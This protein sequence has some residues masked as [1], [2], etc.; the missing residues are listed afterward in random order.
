MSQNNPAQHLRTWRRK[1]SLPGW[2]APLVLL[3]CC[4]LTYGILIP[5]LGVY[6]DDWIFLS[7]Y[8]KMGSAG[9]VRYFATNRPFWGLFYQV[10]LPLLGKTPWHWHLFGLFWHW[11]ASVALW[12]LVRLVW[13]R[14]AK[15]ALWAGL[16]FTV[17]P[18]FI[19]QPIAL[20]V[21]HMFLVYTSFILSICFFV[22]AQLQRRLH[23]S[24][25]RFWFW[26]VLA[27][28]TSLVNLLSM[29]YFLLL[30]LVQPIFL[31]FALSG[32][33]LSLH[34][35]FKHILQAWLPY[36]AMLVGVLLWRIFFFPYQTHN[37]QY[38]LLDRLR[39]SPI[40]G[41]IDLA[42][43]ML[44]DG[45]ETLAGTWVSAL[46]LPLSLP[47]ERLDYA[48]LVLVIA[49]MAVLFIALSQF[50]WSESQA[51]IPPQHGDAA[52]R[53]SAD[54]RQMMFAGGISMLIAGAP[55]WL[56]GITV[57]L[58]GFNSRFTLPFVFGASLLTSGFLLWLPFPQR[59]RLSRDKVQVLVL[60][61]ILGMGIGY[62]FQAQNLFR[63]EWLLQK[64]LY[65]QLAWRIPGL[66]PGT[67]VF[68]S[69]LPLYYNASDYTQ[70]AMFDWNWQPAP[71]ESNLPS[72]M[73]YALYYPNER[74]LFSSLSA[75]EADQPVYVDHLG[76]EFSGNT[77]QSVV[78][79]VNDPAAMTV[80]CLHVMLPE[81]DANNPYFPRLERDVIAFSN[82][83]LILAQDVRQTKQLI[84][85]IF[86]GEPAP[87]HCYYFQKIDLAFQL[88]QWRKAIRLY[89]EA[90]AAGYDSWIDT[91]LVPVIGSFA[92]A[93]DWD[94]AVQLTNQMSKKAFYPLDSFICNLWSVIE[95]DTPTSPAK[96]DAKLRINEKY[97]CSQ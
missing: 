4:A 50:R 73:N 30:H 15:A 49:S 58:D 13:P 97:G 72:R 63:R 18:G 3:A 28:I 55:F 47:W 85:E 54:G 31:W 75:L 84:P 20:T 83:A 81:I 48:Y 96:S 90:V 71:Q 10:T 70:S 12:W 34:R 16:I 95:E 17:Y 57:G 67:I 11:A 38:R 53:D 35:R 40:A 45:W 24:S 23:P 42:R 62:Q 43:T 68:S 77:S 66:E 22:L 59:L 37:Y 29:E 93:A 9:L 91:E 36:L 7:T 25:R 69:E 64:D 88:G 41:L 14:Q 80:G 87:N 1:F 89:E 74:L 56:T 5:W 33:E 26:Q 86:G 76:A 65:W 44:N 32:I 60:A 61:V 6:S 27:L 94:Q 19:L 8:H 2:S 78:L 52:S 92:Q 46:R 79:Q 21:G 39:E 82:P 51:I